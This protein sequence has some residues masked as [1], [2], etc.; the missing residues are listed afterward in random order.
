MRIAVASGKKRA[1]LAT[2]LELCGL[3]AGAVAWC[4]K[5][6]SLLRKHE[7]N[8]ALRVEM[9]SGSPS[10]WFGRALGSHIPRFAKGSSK[11]PAIS[12]N[13]RISTEGNDFSEV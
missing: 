8:F 7:P 13:G 9:R 11:G 12:A 3:R 10:S 6:S 2:G 4:A 5:G 1:K